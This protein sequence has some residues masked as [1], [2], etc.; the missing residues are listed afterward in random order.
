MGSIP[1]GGYGRSKMR[2][3]IIILYIISILALL[4]TGVSLWYYA[5][6]INPTILEMRA[7]NSQ[8]KSQCIVSECDG[9]TEIVCQNG[10]QT[11][12][13]DN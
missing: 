13:L 4:S 11:I 2:K 1:T 6:F 3:H 7:I 9:Y 8:A 10:S 5:T 12:I